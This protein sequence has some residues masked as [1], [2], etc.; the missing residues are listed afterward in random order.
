MLTLEDNKPGN[1]SSHG[2]QSSKSLVF[3]PMQRPAETRQRR[4]EGVAGITV[5]DVD[6]RPHV[7]ALAPLGDGLVE[8]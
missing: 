1:G 2:V 5:E 6:H 4:R 3:Y 8:L 7:A